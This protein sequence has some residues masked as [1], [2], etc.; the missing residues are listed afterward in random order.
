MRT[1][2]MILAVTLGS[3]W[4]VTGCGNSQIQG[5]EPPEAGPG[6]AGMES[7]EAS[8]PFVER[9][10]WLA[11]AE[12]P[13]FHLNQAR[14]L[15]L[16]GQFGPA[17]EE[18]GKVAAILNFESR[19]AHSPYEEGLLLASV[20]ELREVAREARFNDV[21][22]EKL[23][24]VTELDRVEALSFRA[25]AAHQVTLARDALEAGDAR[26]SGRYI[27]EAATALQHG[28]DRAGITLDPVVTRKLDNAR[29]IAARM[30]LKGDGSVEQGLEVLDNL[31]ASVKEL[32]DVVTG[33]RT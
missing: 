24:N 25:I 6:D 2:L 21:P 9:E 27:S 5:S 29:E 7:A 18:L 32:G 28:F 11:L 26:M 10:F 17:S 12:E 31:D 23:P 13:T 20:E 1:K 14:A 30:E 19:H 15:Y 4:C 16:D 22:F 8:P 33:G 3:T